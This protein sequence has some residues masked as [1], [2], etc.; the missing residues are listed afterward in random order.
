MYSPFSLCW[1]FNDNVIGIL[2][3]FSKP[4]RTYFYTDEIKYILLHLTSSFEKTIHTQIKF[5]ILKIANVERDNCPLSHKSVIHCRERIWGYHGWI[6][7][8][9]PK[10]CYNADLI[11][12]TSEIWKFCETATW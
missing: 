2:S 3:L 12:I 4:F 7:Q 5:V 8:K 1:D 6:L 9:Y 10:I 11:T